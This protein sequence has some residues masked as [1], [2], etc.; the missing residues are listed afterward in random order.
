MKQNTF[1]K[2][3]T[4]LESSPKDAILSDLSILPNALRGHINN[5]LSKEFVGNEK[6]LATPVF[7]PMFGWM[8]ADKQFKDLCPDL[9][10][11]SFVNVLDSAVDYGFKKDMHPYTHQIQAWDTLLNT[12]QSL[13]VS[14]GTG[15]GK[16]ES[17]IIPKNIYMIKIV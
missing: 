13:V 9:L 7:E 6:M 2:L 5:L 3:V 11:T 15:S 10:P 1:S 17:F 14:S 16:T 4:E 12:K 8:P